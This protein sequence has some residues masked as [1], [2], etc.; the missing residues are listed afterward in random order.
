MNY[1]GL[2]QKIAKKSKFKRAQHASLVLKGG[3]I[4]AY[5][6]NGNF[7]HSEVRA[8]K[9]LWPSKRQGVTVVN[10]RFTA[11]NSIG[12]SKPCRNCELYMRKAGVQ[13]VIY[14]NANGLFVE[15]RL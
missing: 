10:L 8:L 12:C 2:I 6:H 7:T 1:I 5:A 13:K 11:A 3:A 9:K 14:T 15:E 4:L